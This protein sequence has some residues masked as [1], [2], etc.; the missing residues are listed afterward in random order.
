MQLRLNTP[1]MCCCGQSP[2][3]SCGRCWGEQAGAAQGGEQQTEAGTPAG[4]YLSRALRQAAFYARP[5]GRLLLPATAL[6]SRPCSC[7]RH[8]P[9]LPC[10]RLQLDE[11]ACRS[12]QRAAVHLRCCIMGW[13]GM[14]WGGVGWGVMAI[15]ACRV[16]QPSGCVP[17]SRRTHTHT[18]T[19]CGAGVAAPCPAP[20]PTS[21]YPAASSASSAHAVLT[22]WERSPSSWLYT[23]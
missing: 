4:Q 20:A 7:L 2:L 9:P 14:R 19:Q 6:P 11:A 3:A 22:A 5:P 1:L 12:V 8:L 17:V 10:T 15:H 21:W 13:G 16:G 23:C 18:H